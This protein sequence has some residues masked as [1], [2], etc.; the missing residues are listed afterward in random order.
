MARDNADWIGE[1]FGD[2]SPSDISTLMAA[3]AKTKTS[4]RRAVGNGAKK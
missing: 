4:A 3:L 2:L 1:I